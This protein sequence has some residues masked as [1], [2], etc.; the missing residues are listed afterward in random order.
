MD[1]ILILEQYAILI[2]I[3]SFLKP[4][5]NIKLKSILPLALPILPNMAI[6][7]LLHLYYR[8]IIYSDSTI[9]SIF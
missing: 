6:L 8:A 7:I 9:C 1:S 5:K 2:K 3:I 4:F